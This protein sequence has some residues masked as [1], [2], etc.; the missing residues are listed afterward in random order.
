MNRVILKERLV[1]NIYRLVLEA[2]EI[3][4]SAQAGQFAM[5][6]PDERG[7]RI[8]LN[9]ADWDRQ[10]GT[11]DLVFLNIGV[12]T[13][14][15]ADFKAG[16]SVEGIAGPLGKPVE[17]C[18]SSDVLLVGGCYGIA[19]LYSVARELCHLRNKVL[20]LAE[21]R[22]S[23]FLYW[24]EKIKKYSEVYQTILRSD[25]FNTGQD[26]KDK[27]NQI[28]NGQ[29]EPSLVIVSGCS[30]LL[31]K[32]SEITAG[33]GLRTLVNLNPI[34]VDGTGM[35]GA[36]RV[37]VQGKTRFACVDGPWFDGHSLDWK[38]YFIRRTAFLQQEAQ[39]LTGL[40]KEFWT[41]MG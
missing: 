15:L 14:K 20:F 27:I 1:P 29:P 24:E 8:P 7:E 9:I 32:I 41:K 35:C 34:M 13:R 16:D 26:I 12:S 19:G 4:A 31:Y 40:E 22:G 25:C 38:E 36:C 18:S 21:A 30:Y 2:P 17:I 33:S 23:A 10:K 28:K 3:A 5:V 39:A 11:I 37:T 6:I